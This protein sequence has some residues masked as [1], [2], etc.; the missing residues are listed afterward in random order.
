VLRIQIAD[1]GYAWQ[2]ASITLFTAALSFIGAKLDTADRK[3]LVVVQIALASG[4]YLALLLWARL[5]LRF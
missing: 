3:T 4:A 5:R 2:I 1:D